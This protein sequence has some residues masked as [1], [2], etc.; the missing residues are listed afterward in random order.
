MCGAD[1]LMLLLRMV[2]DKSGQGTAGIGGRLFYDKSGY[3][4]LFKKTFLSACPPPP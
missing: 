2:G 4:M 1:S 3:T